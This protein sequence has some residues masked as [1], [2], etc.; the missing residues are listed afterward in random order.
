MEIG[1]YFWIGINSVVIT[2]IIVGVLRRQG[3]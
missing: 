3:T 2:Y 1:A